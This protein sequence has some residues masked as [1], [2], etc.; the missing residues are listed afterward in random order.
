MPVKQEGLP[1]TIERSPKKVQRTYAK[2]LDSA[3]EQYDSEER[4]HRT[5][6]D[7]VK[8]VAE[9]K[10]DRWVL[11]DETGP[12]DPQAAQ[13]GRRA[14]EQ[15]KETYGG[16]DASKPKSELYEEAK[17]AGIE[18][19]STMDKRE[20]AKALQKHNDRETAKARR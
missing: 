12:S 1:S 18:G 16:V 9:K 13:S 19:R 14:R 5:A 11:K 20:L 10:G 3:H 15:P 17:K 6:Y 8:R 2:T 7:S 4:A